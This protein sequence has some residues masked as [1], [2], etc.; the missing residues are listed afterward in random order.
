MARVDM[1]FHGMFHRGARLTSKPVIQRILSFLLADYPLRT[2][3][4]RLDQS[5]A[6]D[7]GGSIRGIVT[8]EVP[9]RRSCILGNP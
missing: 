5:A 3:Q 2:G 9:A 1:A 6:D 7:I 4:T 8:H